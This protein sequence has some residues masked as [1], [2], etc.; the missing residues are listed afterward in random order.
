MQQTCGLV[1]IFLLLSIFYCTLFGLKL[2]TGNRVVD[3]GDEVIKILMGWFSIMA[4]LVLWIGVVN[5]WVRFREIE[6]YVRVRGWDVESQTQMVSE[7]YSNSP[8]VHAALIASWDYE[9]SHFRG[10]VGLSPIGFATIDTARRFID[11]H[12]ADGWCILAVNPE[13]PKEAVLD[14]PDHRLIPV[15]YI[16]SALLALFATLFVGTSIKDKCYSKVIYTI[17]QWIFQ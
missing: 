7:E 15:V 14:V 12:V 2:E 16:V 11:K 13:N 5:I 17:E 10:Y 6:Q 1:A 8:T 4:G 9:G 3:L